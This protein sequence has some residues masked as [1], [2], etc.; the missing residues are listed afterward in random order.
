MYVDELRLDEEASDPDGDG[1]AG[2]LNEWSSSHTDPFL[3]DTDGDGAND[4]VDTSPLN[5]N[6]GFV[7]A[8]TVTGGLIDSYA[9][10][11][12]TLWQ[13]GVPTSGPKSTAGITSD[14]YVWA[15]NLAGNFGIDER[16]YLYLPL[17]DLT[18]GTQ[19]ILSMRL[20][21]TSWYSDGT[22]LQMFDPLTSTWNVIT[23]YSTTQQYDTTAVP[24]VGTAWG[25]IGTPVTGAAAY[26]LSAFD[27]SAWIGGTMQLRFAFFSNNNGNTTGMY[28]DELRLDEEASDPDGDGIAG[29][30]NEWNTYGTDP[31]KLDT[32]GDG[33]NDNV[34][35]A[36][37]TNPLSNTS[38]PVLLGVATSVA[39]TASQPN[40]VAVGHLN[41]DAYAD[42]IAGDLAGK[43]YV[44]TGN[45]SAALSAPVIYDSYTGVMNRFSWGFVNADPYVD[46]VM[47][48]QTLDLVAVMYGDAAGI[49]SPYSYAI[50]TY[51]APT[52]A[53]VT[54]LNRDGY[55]DI[56][57]ANYAEGTGSTL[58]VLQGTGG[59]FALA[60]PINLLATTGMYGITADGYS[61]IAVTQFNGGVLSLWDQYTMTQANFTVG[62]SP[63]DVVG[64]Y[65]NHDNYADLVVVNSAAASIS[66]LFGSG[67]G[68]FS[69][70]STY[71]TSVS[72]QP[73]QAAIGDMDGDG[74]P[75]IVVSE[76]LTHSVGILKGDGAGNF[77]P[78]MTYVVTG[79]TDPEGIALG[80]LNGDG[81][82]DVVL[83][84]RNS[85]NLS[86]LLNTGP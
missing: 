28:V 65:L 1:I 68:N 29:V 30:L 66:V 42:V 15:T 11:N 9:M 67:G 26:Q 80:D 25:N 20:W 21:S 3:I 12:G 48:S 58:S 13:Y 63:T 5:P 38:M 40:S 81:R 73:R 23:P 57:T 36:R 33:F 54:D 85:S 86:V 27:L 7:G 43:L 71:L 41:G 6:V 2:V 10:T 24:V 79:A 55:S 19:P 32:D 59:G 74:H 69:S 17:V 14:P 76:S 53:V 31:F 84:N 45:G 8:V 83:S 61:G 52:S 82:L 56:V 46:I 44:Y 34:E 75:D 49:F 60:T 70:P 22:V 64:G 51:A 77:Y 50:D 72:S 35:I 37:G 47:P 78:V 62:A 18:A 39:L 16:A 4:S